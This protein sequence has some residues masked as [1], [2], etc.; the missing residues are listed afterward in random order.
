MFEIINMPPLGESITEGTITRWFKKEGEW[1]EEGEPLLEVSTDKVDTEIPSLKSGYIKKILVKE[2]ET[3][4]IG[5]PLA[6]ISKDKNISSTNSI[7]NDS[8]ESKKDDIY[9]NSMHNNGIPNNAN[10]V[11]YTTP[12]IRKLAQKYKIDLNVIKGTGIGGRIRKT[13]VL[14]EMRQNKLLNNRAGKI[15]K[16]LKNEYLQG[17]V[18]KISRIRETIANRMRYSLDTATQLTQVIELDVSLIVKTREKMKKKIFEKHKVNLTF[19]PFFMKSIAKTLIDHP[20]FNAYYDMKNKQIV[21]YK[22]Q[23]I[24]FAVDTDRGLLVPVINSVDSLNIVNIAKKINYLAVRARDHSIGPD[25][26]SGGTFTVTNIG[27]FGSLFDTPIINQPQS[28]I[29]GIGAIVKRPIVVSLKND[30]LITIKSMVYISLTYDHRI[31]D[32]ADTGRFFKSLRKN[33]E[34]FN[35]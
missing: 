1:I 32:G 25:E 13:D 17:K 7:V 29:L 3:I 26:L 2:T 5:N 30:D 28:S 23:N 16:I 21:Y 18:E 34:I 9:D 10:G 11:A 19:M 15:K 31:I 14:N 35:Y 27:S 33:L 6:H 20:K 12:L 22:T 4:Y 24:A 8:K